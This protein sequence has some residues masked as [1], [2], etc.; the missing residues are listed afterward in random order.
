L[1]SGG[2]ESKKQWF[3]RIGGFDTTNYLQEDGFTA[4]PRFWDTTLLGQLI[5]FRPV[6]YAQGG[7]LSNLQPYY[8]PGTVALYVKDIKFPIG[9]RPGTQPLSLVYSSP[10]FQGNAPGLVF[11][12]LI[13][14]VNHNY[15]PKI[16]SNPY[17]EVFVNVT[18]PAF[19]PLKQS[20]SPHAIRSSSSI[21]S[22]NEL[23]GSSVTNNATTASKITKTMKN[24]GHMNM[25][26]TK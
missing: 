10:S 11:A 24:T 21:P 14:K 16:T 12:V 4:T 2:D 18:H 22:S 8:S 17:H 9:P 23:I 25:P 26:T 15:V 5:P 19:E 1:G 3:M 7:Q 6:L 20:S 13:Y